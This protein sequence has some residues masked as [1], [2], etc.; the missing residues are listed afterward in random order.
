VQTKVK[1][2]NLHINKVYSTYDNLRCHLYNFSAWI[3]WC[4]CC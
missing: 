2:W 3:I 1:N 4:C